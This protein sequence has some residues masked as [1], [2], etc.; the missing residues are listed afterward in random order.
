M[1]FT[2]MDDMLAQIS[3]GKIGRID[4]NKLITPAQVAGYW[5]NVMRWD[6]NPPNSTYPGDSLTYYPTD[7]TSP[8]AP[9][10]G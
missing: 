2:S 6:G 7:N 9:Y 4:I 5:S 1:G 3:A 8:G 10:I